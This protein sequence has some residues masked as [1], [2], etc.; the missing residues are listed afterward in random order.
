MRSVTHFLL[1]VLGAVGLLVG[2]FVGSTCAQTVVETTRTEVR[3]Y[4]VHK[5]VTVEFEP[6]GEV[7]HVTGRAW[8]LANPDG[9]TIRVDMSGMPT[10][11]EYYVYEVDDSGAVT[12]L[13]TLPVREGI[14]RVS[15]RSR[16]RK[17]RMFVSPEPELTSYGLDT[18]VILRS[19]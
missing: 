17:F 16:H 13:G 15:F 3:E 9:S 12:R 4:P 10:D 1:L 7:G 11:R 19:R 14:A 5:R 18:T 2:S 6:V 8:V